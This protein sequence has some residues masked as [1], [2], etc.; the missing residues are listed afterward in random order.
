MVEQ[1]DLELTSTHEYLKNTSTCPTFSLKTNC[2]L[3]ESPLHNRGNEKDPRGLG[4][5]RKDE[6][7]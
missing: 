2:K 6:I 1:E 3:A 7:M 5:K 4:E